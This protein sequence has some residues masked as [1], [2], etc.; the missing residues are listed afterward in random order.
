MTEHGYRHLLDA[1]KIPEISAGRKCVQPKW[2]LL[3]TNSPARLR[4]ATVVHLPKFVT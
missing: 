2:P 3:K 4:G 1:D